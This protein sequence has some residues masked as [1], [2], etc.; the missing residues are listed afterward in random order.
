MELSDM[1]NI[2][3]V[4]I[5][6]IVLLHLG[7]DPEIIEDTLSSALVVAACADVVRVF[8]YIMKG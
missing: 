6:N 2:V 8:G 5:A 7:A 3:L 4:L 1:S